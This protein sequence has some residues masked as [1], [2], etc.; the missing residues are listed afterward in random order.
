[1]PTNLYKMFRAIAFVIL[2]LFGAA[3]CGS[4]HTHTDGAEAHD[5][6][7]HEH[8]AATHTHDDMSSM[9]DTAGTYVDTTTIDMND[10]P[11]AD[12]DHGEGADH[13]H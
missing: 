10:E 9:A 8:G 3:G 12:H 11:A 1:M 5:D 2:L 6:E 4:D 7:T 13:E